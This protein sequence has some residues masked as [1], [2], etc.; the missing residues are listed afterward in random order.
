MA[1]NTAKEQM[2][3][4]I[5][6]HV[7][8]GKSTLV[9]R[10]FYD[11]GSLPE[12]KYE[13]IMETC[14]KRG[15]PFEWSFLMDA[16]QAERDQGI[17]ID[18]AQIWFKTKKR[19]YVIID[20]PGHKEFLK[21][22]ISG[23]ASS[24]A[25]VLVIDAKEGVM[26]Q[27][28]RHG[29]LLHLLGIKQIAVAVNK[30]D[31]VG[32]SEE[33]FRVLEKEYRSYLASIG[34]TPT[35][36][37]PISG[38]EGDHIIG[39]SKHMP[40]YKGPSIV[41]A[42]DK[43]TPAPG[44]EDQPLRFPV[45]DV[46]KFDERRIIAGRIESGRIKV[47]DELLFSP[48]NRVVRVKSIESWSTKKQPTEAAAGE[49]V[50]ITLDEQIFAERGQVISHVDHA[51]M[52][53]NIFRARLFWLGD[54]PLVANKRYKIKLG[55]SEFP[56]EVQDIEKVVSTDDLSHVDATKV[57]RLSVAE[58]VFHIKGLAALDPFDK[59]TRTGRF[60]VVEGYDVVGGGI[61][62][63]KGFADQCVGVRE[64][65]SKNIYAVGQSISP[66]Q[67]AKYNGHVGGI[68]WFTGLSG[69]GKS[70]LA[71]ELEKRLFDRGIQVYVLDGDNV[72]RGLN[73]D[74][75]FSPEDRSENIRRVGEAAALFA[76]AGFIV[77]T[78]FISPYKA[79]RD[80]ARTAAPEKFNLIYVKASVETCEK[81]DVKGLYKKARKGEIKEF[82]GISAPYEA[83]ESPELVVDTTDRD[84]DDCIDELMEYVQQNFIDP[85]RQNQRAARDHLG[86]DDV[87][88]IGKVAG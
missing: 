24:E 86:E 43:F 48:R 54:N 59:N 78:S 61:I 87:V 58:V 47:G 81:R 49:S 66:E 75:G 29:Y 18:T 21:N 56:A 76:D 14:E 20:A 74:L 60:V 46:Y 32:Y 36:V 35:F 67:R 38:R 72:R 6:G 31:M 19:N 13:Q 33:R 51:P 22:M 26:E 9:G 3:I 23:A 12:G 8:H 27:S 82:T 25:A 88:R 69:A 68:L 44:L 52:L 77:I 10:L 7:D 17:T 85:V 57:E 84:I 41:E 37:I 71:L 50:G 15:M 70:T 62:D 80:I 16:L 45:Q 2:K 34:V 79:D 39:A 1:K 4:V 28:R 11:T 65:K 63:M 42:L 83:P 64:I 73:S 55:T 40:W 30:M 53:T 5:V